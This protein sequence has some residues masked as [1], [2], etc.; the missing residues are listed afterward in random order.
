MKFNKV[1]FMCKYDLYL[2]GDIISCTIKTKLTF[3]SFKPE[4]IE[5]N[6]TH[7]AINLIE[8]YYKNLNEAARSGVSIKL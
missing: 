7:L 2:S 8:L 5:F 3:N 1:K 4:I 6:L